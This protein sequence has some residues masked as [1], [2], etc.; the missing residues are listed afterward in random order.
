M[1]GESRK[2][3]AFGY[4]GFYREREGA[5][6]GTVGSPYFEENIN[7]LKNIKFQ[8]NNTAGPRSISKPEL[9]YEFNKYLS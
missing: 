4:G 8:H 7:K 6:G 9:I 3:V 1:F 5:Y 2:D